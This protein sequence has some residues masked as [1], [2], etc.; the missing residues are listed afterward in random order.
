MNTKATMG[1]AADRLNAAIQAA[2]DVIRALKYGVFASVPFQVQG[3]DYQL[4]HAKVD[5]V[6]GLVVDLPPPPGQHGRQLL[7]LLH[8]SVE[9]RTHAALYIPVL[10]QRMVDVFARRL[11]LI[12]EVTI[13]LEVFAGGLADTEDQEAYLE[14]A[15]K[16]FDSIKEG[17][18]T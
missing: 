17:C 10:V 9:V 2:E 12:D 4:L 16:Q 8:T 5:R 6:W 14:R 18:T 15:I 11:D 13:G 1:E 7:P 3:E